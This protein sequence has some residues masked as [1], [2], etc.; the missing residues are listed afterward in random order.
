M[1]TAEQR[2]AVVA[3]ALSW[4]GTRWHH[5]ARIKGSGVDCAQLVAAVYEQCGVVA[6]VAHAPYPRDWA[7]HQNRALLQEQI[8]TYAVRVDTP[9]PGDV[10]GFRFGQCVSHVGLVVDWP[11]IVHA[12]LGARH[13]VVDDAVR[14][15][16]LAAAYAG[17]WSPWRD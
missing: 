2:A 17:A 12:Y 6:K 14:N 10:V 4:V 9:K 3:E 1:T 16:G 13:V 15:S 11:T 7:Q 8:E 5:A